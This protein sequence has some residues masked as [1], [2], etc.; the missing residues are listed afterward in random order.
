MS[1]EEKDKNEKKKP[2][3]KR[4][5]KLC[6][7]IIM[8]AALA[9]IV[10]K[11]IDMDI[12]IKQF[13]SPRVIAAL[14]IGIIVQTIIWLCAGYP[15]K[16][17]TQSLSGK[18]IPFS[19]VMPVY[20]RSNIYKYLPG[21]VLQYVGRNQLASN[22]KISH[23]DVACATILDIIFCVIGTGIVS[24]ILLG[25]RISELVV[26]Y[27]KQIA[28]VGIIG[29]IL[30]AAVVVVMYIKFREKLREYLRRYSKALAPGNRA[31][32]AKGILYYFGQ[33][34]LSAVM[35]F[36][37][38]SLI[39]NGEASV[40]E[41]ITYTGAFLFAWIVGFVTIGAPGGIGIRE[42]VMIFICGEKFADKILL[43]VLVMRVASTIADVLAFFIGKVYEKRRASADSSR[44]LSH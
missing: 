35:Y 21:N 3:L 34:A 27:G 17:F 37:S 33:N 41:L 23:V 36:V 22:M 13:K 11:F 7:N 20:T 44:L 10:K 5:A 6:G 19:E 2:D 29:V 4:W 26:E 15:W 25:S 28:I 14:V 39:F 43:F 12:D 40:S 16:V 18:K 30:I 1:D 42:S 38:L 24:V 8:I 9:F 32:L 31:N